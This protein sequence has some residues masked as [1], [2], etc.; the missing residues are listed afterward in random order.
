MPIAPLETPRL[1][2]R[3]VTEADAPGFLAYMQ[4]EAYWQSVPIDPP[5]PDSIAAMVAARLTEQAADPRTSFFLAAADRQTGQVVGEA[6]LHIRSLR[7]AQG[8]IGWGVA[9]GRAGQGLGT[10]IGH[11]MLHLAFRQL[12]L[13]RVI[14]QCRAENRP[15]QRIMEK[16]GMRQEGMF[17]DNVLARGAW[18]SSAQYAILEPEW[19]GAAAE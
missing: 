19:L 18:W 9:A 6:I 1:R 16:L 17:R 4:E 11:A 7:W 2:I 12:R 15:S 10:E 8:E 14:A 13:H 5:T 3:D